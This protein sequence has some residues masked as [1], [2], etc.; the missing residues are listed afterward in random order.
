MAMNGRILRISGPCQH[1]SRSAAMLEENTGYFNHD[2]QPY[3]Y[4]AARGAGREK[5]QHAAQRHQYSS[6]DPS[7]FHDSAY[8]H[9]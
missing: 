2:A 7:W 5:Q 6:H 9:E 1:H 3:Q 4:G 8:S